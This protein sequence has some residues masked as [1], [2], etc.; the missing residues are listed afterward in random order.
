VWVVY[1]GLGS[2]AI[3]RWMSSPPCASCLDLVSC[4][5]WSRSSLC[6]MLCLLGSDEYWVLCQVDLW[7][8][9]SMLYMILHALRC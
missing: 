2:I 3:A 7:F 1:L 4:L 6:Y 9:I 8:I 5:S